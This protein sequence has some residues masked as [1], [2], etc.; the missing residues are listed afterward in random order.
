MNPITLHELQTL[1]V[2][3]PD[4]E[5]PELKQLQRLI[6]KL[7]TAQVQVAAFGMVGRGKSSL[8]NALM[9]AAVCTVGLRHGTT[10][11]LHSAGLDLD[12]ASVRLS[13]IDTPGIHAIEGEARARLAHYAARRADVI[14]FVVAGDLLAVEVDALQQLQHYG[15]PLILVCNKLDLYNDRDRELLH[16]RLEQYHQPLVWV[17]AD[18]KQGERTVNISAL[19][20]QLYDLLQAQG[21]ALVLRTVQQRGS[22][23]RERLWQARLD[24]VR[25]PAER[26][27]QV[28][29][30]AKLGLLWLLPGAWLSSLV[31]LGLDIGLILRLEALY[32][33]KRPA[34]AWLTLWQTIGRNAAI[35]TGLELLGLLPFHSGLASLAAAILLYDLGQRYQ[36]SVPR[37]RLSPS[38]L[39]I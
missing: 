28:A 24:Q 27:I 23:L 20:T 22:Q 16:H 17:A 4:R 26:L 12:L 33:F 39:D 35:V 14:V 8:I 6:T 25:Q 37:D 31:S 34:A 11:A 15:K 10:Q 13:F 36:R 2:T 5:R 18:P 21:R 1:I 7:K 19:Q 3:W 32:G 38:T 29:T 30:L 9:G